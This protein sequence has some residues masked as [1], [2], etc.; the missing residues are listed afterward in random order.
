MRRK[1]KF[2]KPLIRALDKVFV[3]KERKKEDVDNLNT[4][5]NKYRPLK[6][7]AYPWKS[8]EE[9]E[10]HFLGPDPKKHKDYKRLLGK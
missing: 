2:S 4:L 5:E 10:E 9:A 3:N 1:L 8:T 7:V 6:N